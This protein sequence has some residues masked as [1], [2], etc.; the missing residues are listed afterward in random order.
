VTEPMLATGPDESDFPPAFVQGL[1]AI[2]A[3]ILPDAVVEVVDGNFAWIRLGETALSEGLYTVPKARLWART[4]L[5]FPNAVP[6]GVATAP[7]LVRTDGRAVDRQHVGHQMVQAL[8]HVVGTTDLA[9]YSWDWNNMPTRD[10]EDLVAVVEWAR[11]RLR[12]G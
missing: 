12:E 7:I 6:Y 9:F 1:R 11:R 2:R 8:A 5:T 10:A 4:P 3:R